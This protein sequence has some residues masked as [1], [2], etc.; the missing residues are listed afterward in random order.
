MAEAFG[1]P[2]ALAQ[3]RCMLT[4][5]TPACTRLISRRPSS[6]RVG[7]RSRS[8]SSPSGSRTIERSVPGG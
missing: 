2:R 1:A 5:G 7:R 6:P 3:G 4:F 8:T